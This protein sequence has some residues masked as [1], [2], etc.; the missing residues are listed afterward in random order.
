M[1]VGRNLSGKLVT[2]PPEEGIEV[3]FQLMVSNRIRHL[4]V[5]EDDRLVG[6]LSDRDL[7]SALIHSRKSEAGRDFFFIPP[8][9]AVS[10]VMTKDPFS[11][12]PD[13]DVEEA[14]RLM[15]R[16]KIGSLPVVENGRVVG[17]ITESDILAIFIEIMGVIE[18]SSR[19]DVEMEDKPE[20]LEKA[21]EII[22]ES[23]GKIISI[24]MSP[25][26]GDLRTY[27][28]RLEM[29]DTSPVVEALKKAGFK[30]KSA[31]S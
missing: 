2:V 7:K 4:P 26:T 15:Y 5:V 14:A 11:V 6:I 24:A 27:Y 3:A 31:L 10:E 18:S 25:V 21:A 1:K 9:V 13:S 19:V 30:V 23:C 16:K 17:I 28:F 20:N 29:C 22:R 8:G 12:S